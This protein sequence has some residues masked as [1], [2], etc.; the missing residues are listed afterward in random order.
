MYLIASDY[1]PKHGVARVFD[2]IGNE[3]RYVIECDTESGY[4]E[5]YLQTE[6]GYIAGEENGG[7]LR[8]KTHY[9]PPLRIEPLPIEMQSN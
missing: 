6:G 1:V 3:I 9:L 7:I 4:V 2:A 8:E 5:K